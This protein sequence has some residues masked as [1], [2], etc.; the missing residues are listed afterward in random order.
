[1]NCMKIRS[2]FIA[3]LLI[4]L[5]LSSCE[6]QCT[7]G[8]DTKEEKGKVRKEGESLLYNGI[9]LRA[10]G[11]KVNKAYLVTNDG[12]GERIGED[13]I[14]DLKKGVKLLLLVSNDWKTTDDHVWLGASMNVNTETGEKIL[15][16]EDMFAAYEKEGLPAKDAN[17]IGMSVRFKEQLASLPLSYDVRFRVWDKKGEAFIEG[18]YTIHTR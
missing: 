8:K 1:M 16:Q 6:F 12:N 11:I 5:V 18:S 13:N 17:I 14:I 15:E 10:S 4:T 7:V 3:F 2:L 9:Q